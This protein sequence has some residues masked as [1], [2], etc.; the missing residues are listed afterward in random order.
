MTIYVASFYGSVAPI[1]FYAATF[2]FIPHHHLPSKYMNVCRRVKATRKRGLLV[3]PMGRKKRLFCFVF[4]LIS[5]KGQH[6]FFMATHFKSMAYLEGWGERDWECKTR[7]CPCW[8]TGEK[9]T[10]N[11]M[12]ILLQVREQK[13]TRNPGSRLVSLNTRDWMPK[14]WQSEKKL[15]ERRAYVRLNAKNAI[16]KDHS[17][18]H[19]EKLLK[20]KNQ[21]APW[22]FFF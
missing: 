4:I 21:K 13:P 7:H 5:F 22:D 17:D 1:L 2:T 9:K 3:L 15:Y 12:D 6:A 11:D 18:T 19:G 16:Q 20:R 14:A 10:Y 8:G